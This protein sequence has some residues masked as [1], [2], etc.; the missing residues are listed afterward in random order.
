MYAVLLRVSVAAIG[1]SAAAPP[2]CLAQ[3][4]AP[5]AR[6]DVKVGDRWAYRRM[7]YESGQPV[8][9]YEM[10]VSFAE[11]GVIHVVS[12]LGNTTEEA[13]MTF[14]DN[15][16]AVSAKEAIFYPHNGW[17]RFPMRPGD[18]YQARYEAVRPGRDIRVQHERAVIVH[19]WE[20]I[21]VP[22]GTFRALKVE[23]QGPFRIVDRPMR[24][25]SRNVLW[26][27]PEVR[28][29]AKMLVET[30]TPRGRMDYSGEELL[31]YELK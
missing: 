30:N 26:Y 10:R 23:S 24:G 11:R 27:V 18:T 9:R 19:G 16:N 4:D 25:R 8:G 15:W 3:T 5:V 29:W 1:L 21:T 17:L 28:R 20:E 22:A 13:D 12:T 6:P 7:D 14:T 2:P 31:S